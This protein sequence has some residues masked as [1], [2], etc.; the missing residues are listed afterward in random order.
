MPSER[1]DGVNLG[2]VRD[3]L[4]QY[5]TAPDSVD[6]AW[7]PVFEEAE[8]GLVAEHPA[9][10]RAVAL[11]AHAGIAVPPPAPPAPAPVVPAPAAPSPA[12]ADAPAEDLD[13]LLGGVAAAMALVKAHRM[14][15]HLAA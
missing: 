4:D 2:Y 13:E 10:R 7:R 5:L 8:N 3:L 1:V 12:P 14:H 15:G 9:V 11:A 6:P